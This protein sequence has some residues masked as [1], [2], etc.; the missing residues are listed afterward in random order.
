MTVRE[1]IA[2]LSGFDPDLKVVMPSERGPEF[3]EVDSAYIDLVR[4]ID[5]GAELTD[6]READRNP[7][8]RLFG[9]EV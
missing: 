9:P 8:V 7:V 3:C 2:V 5:G 6:E 1:L 4:F